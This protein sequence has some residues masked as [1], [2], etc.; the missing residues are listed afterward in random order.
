MAFDTIPSLATQKIL[1]LLKIEYSMAERPRMRLWIH[2]TIGLDFNIGP[3]RE[4]Q[5]SLTLHKTFMTCAKTQC[6]GRGILLDYAE[7][8]AC[9]SP[10][11]TY[12]TFS[13]H[14]IPFSTL[15]ALCKYH[16]VTPRKGDILFIRTGIISEW[17]SFSDQQKQ[18]YAAQ[19]EPTHAGVEACLE[20]L[21]WLWNSGISAVAGDSISWEVSLS[22]FNV[23]DLSI[24]RSVLLPFLSG[25]V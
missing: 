10:P 1:Q 18:D 17:D 14:S 7:W 8:A 24:Q 9:Q 23:V 13:T 21:E 20:T 3:H 12:S 6:S 25:T 11:V 22:L 5:V 16:N 19:D 2:R 15:L 4:L